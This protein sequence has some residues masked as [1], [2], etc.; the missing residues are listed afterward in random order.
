MFNRVVPGPLE[1]KA[2]IGFFDVPILLRVSSARSGQA[3]FHAFGGPSVGFRVS[4]GS[5]LL[6]EGESFRVHISD[7]IKRLDL[8]LVAGAG[9]DVG[10]FTI[11]GRYSWGLTDLNDDPGEEVTIKNRVFSVMAGVKF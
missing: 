10:R 11:D 7:K 5:R 6:I 4:A 3:S 1:G 2:K 9:V 8:G